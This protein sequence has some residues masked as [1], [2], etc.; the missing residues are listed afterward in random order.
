MLTLNL[1]DREGRSSRKFGTLTVHA[2]ETV[3]SRNAVEITFR[4]AALVNKDLFSKSVCIFRFTV[5]VAMVSTISFSMFWL[6]M[7]NLNFQDPFL[8]ISRTVETGGAVPI[9]KTEVVNNNL[10][11]TWKP[12]CLTM[13]QFMSKVILLSTWISLLLLIYFND[14]IHLIFVCHKFILDFLFEFGILKT[15]LA[16]KIIDRE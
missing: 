14:K 6:N 12:V 5:L 2:E 10:N 15:L 13:Q 9:C 11:P 4:C 3:A 7:M 16:N 8:R 1:C